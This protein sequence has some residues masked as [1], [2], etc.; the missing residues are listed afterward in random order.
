MAFY[1]DATLRAVLSRQPDAHQIGR[2]ERATSQLGSQLELSLVTIAVRSTLVVTGTGRMACALAA[3][4]VLPLTDMI[5]LC[6]AYPVAASMIAMPAP[7][8]FHVPI[9]APLFLADKRS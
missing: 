4:A 6:Q 9:L 1:F 8:S 7:Q 5:P 2:P 3:A